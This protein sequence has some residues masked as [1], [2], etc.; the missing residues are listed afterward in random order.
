MGGSFYIHPHIV[1]VIDTEFVSIRLPVFIRIR[2]SLDGIWL[3]F[4]LEARTG[5]GESMKAGTGR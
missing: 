5:E 4:Q 3:R 1:N 2:L